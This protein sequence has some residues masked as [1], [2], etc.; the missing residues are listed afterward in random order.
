MVA[1]G[2][3]RMVARC[4]FHTPEPE[5]LYQ[6]HNYNGRRDRDER[7]QHPE[8]RIRAPAFLQDRG[9]AGLGEHLAGP[10][11]VAFYLLLRHAAGARPQPGEIPAQRVE[12]CPPAGREAPESYLE[13]RRGPRSGAFRS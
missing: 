6:D 5:L 8:G 2:I 3:P 12:L 1:P 9:S 13:I 10:S 4:F 7:A 11:S